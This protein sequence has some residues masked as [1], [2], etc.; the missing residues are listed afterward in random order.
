MPRRSRS[1]RRRLPTFDAS[2][3]RSRGRGR[4]GSLNGR[5]VSC[6]RM[7]LPYARRSRPRFGP[8]RAGTR[9]RAAG[10][11]GSGVSGVAMR[12]ASSRSPRPAPSTRR[13]H[14]ARPATGERPFLDDDEPVRLADRARTVSR[15]NGRSVRRSITSTDDALRCE[16]APPPR[17]CRGRSS[18]RVTSVMSRPSRTTAASP[19]RRRRAVHLALER[20]EPLVLEEEHRVVV[21]DRGFQQRLRV[22]RRGRAH[23]LEAG[24]AHE[25][26][27]PASASGS[28][29]S[30]RRR[31]PRSGSRAAR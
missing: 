20:V 22:G 5:S 14:L 23:D 11:R 13:E 21:A 28:R 27:R 16:R 19:S 10:C 18:S 26:R 7:P 29:R 4:A 9:P 6:L 31:R 25:P 15:S 1:A 17:G 2:R 30:G 8:A 24:D 3:P 12:H